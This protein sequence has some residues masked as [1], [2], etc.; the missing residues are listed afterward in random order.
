[1]KFHL[2]QFR[3][4]QKTGLRSNPLRSPELERARLDRLAVILEKSRMYEEGR[5]GVRGF[6]GVPLAHVMLGSLDRRERGNVAAT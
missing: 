6:S 1:M 2:A 4:L 5:G 3:Q